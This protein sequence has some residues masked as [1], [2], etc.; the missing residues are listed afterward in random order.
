MTRE[1]AARAFAE[2]ANHPASRHIVS[3]IAKPGGP[4][5][6]GVVTRI[7]KICGATDD[8]TLQAPSDE[9]DDELFAWFKNFCDAHVHAEGNEAT[10]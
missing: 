3:R 8:K 6:P 9:F 5:T 2:L 7:C 1:E 4:C 10:S